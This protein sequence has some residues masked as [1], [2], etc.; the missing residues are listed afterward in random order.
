[1][2]SMPFR[3]LKSFLK[4][5]GPIWKPLTRPNSGSFPPAVHHFSLQYTKYS[6]EKMASSG[7]KSLA[8]G[9]ISGFQIGPNWSSVWKGKMPRPVEKGEAGRYRWGVS[10][11]WGRRLLFQRSDRP[12]RRRGRHSCTWFHLPS[13]A[14]VC[15]RAMPPENA[16]WQYMLLE[17]KKVTYFLDRQE[18][19]G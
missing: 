15:P 5:L 2:N 7:G 11:R 16:T 10:A 18:K 8:V 13:G 9:H 12:D 19:F 14:A 1:M 17:A 4:I 6:C 3:Q